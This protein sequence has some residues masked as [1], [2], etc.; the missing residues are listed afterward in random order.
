MTAES[1]DLVQRF[2]AIIVLAV[3]LFVVMTYLLSMGLGIFVFFSNTKGLEFS[4]ELIQLPFLMFT[5]VEF[6]VNAGLYFIFLWC[7]FALC[8]GAAAKSRE[9][10]VGKSRETLFGT[11]KSL[12]QNNLLAMPAIASMLLV[13]ILA[14]YYLQNQVGI[15]TGEPSQGEPLLDF[16]WF[17]RAPLVEEI[18]FRIIPIGAFL[19]TYIPLAGRKVTLAFSPSQR[20]KLSVLSILQPDRAK[21][22]VNLK[23]I[24]KYGLLGGMLGAEWMMVALTALLFGFAHYLGGWGP[25]KISQAAISG[26]VFAVAYLYYG[27]QAPILLHWFFNYYFN[28]FYL[29]YDYIAKIDLTYII[30]STNLSFGVFLWL[31]VLIFG[32]LA[33]FRM[34]GKK[35]ELQQLPPNTAQSSLL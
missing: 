26:A 1:P 8:F 21:E 11:A 19:A 30:E 23:T 3:S 24:N 25:G 33:L 5:D 13:A 7:V 17:S 9:S 32:G 12:F 31:A 6:S 10:L 4:R 16:I 27:V 2:F 29:A 34:F 18:V 28:V 35:P 22:M 20:L 15:P 14:L